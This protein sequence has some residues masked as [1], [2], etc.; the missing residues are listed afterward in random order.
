MKPLRWRHNY[1]CEMLLCLKCFFGI[2]Y[3]GVNNQR[4]EDDTTL[5]RNNEKSLQTRAGAFLFKTCEL[6]GWKWRRL[7][8]WRSPCFHENVQLQRKTVRDFKT[9]QKR[10]TSHRCEFDASFC[11]HILR[12]YENSCASYRGNFQHIPTRPLPNFRS[13]KRFFARANTWRPDLTDCWAPL[14][15][16]Q[17]ELSRSARA[18]HSEMVGTK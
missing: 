15:L 17:H 3:G 13:L 10:I 6:T 16:G 1:A 2:T 4:D 18:R 14:K 11:D 7:S 9:G 5:C 12:R 8:S